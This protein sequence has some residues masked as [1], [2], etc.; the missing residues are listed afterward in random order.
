MI[1]FNDISVKYQN[2]QVLFDCSGTIK[3]GKITAIIGQNGSGKST[4]LKTLTG[5]IRP[6]KGE[7][8]IANKKLL[9]YSLDELAKKRAIFMQGNSISF[10]Y[11]VNDVVS[12]GRSPYFKKIENSN[13][14]R[15]IK[16]SLESVDL[17]HKHD[18]NILTL[19]GGEQQRVH[20]ARVLSQLIDQEAEKCIYFFDEPTNNLDVFHQFKIMNTLSE[21]KEKGYTIVTVLHDLNLVSEFADEII[22]MKDGQIIEHGESK[23]TLNHSLLSHLYNFRVKTFNHPER[24]HQMIIY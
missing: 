4:L 19:S 21:L 18:A 20:I 13:D 1:H 23:T 22:A 8:F 15:I 11:S 17:A 2:T 16:Q 5:H 6:S 7:I 24:K 12:L 10:P 9:D 14:R 3:A